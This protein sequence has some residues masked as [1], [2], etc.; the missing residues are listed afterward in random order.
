LYNCILA[1]SYELELLKSDVTKIKNGLKKWSQRDWM[2]FNILIPF[3]KACIKRDP[4]GVVLII[5]P[6][7][8]Y[9]Y[10]SFKKA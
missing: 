6:L 3:D 8:I 9:I 4:Y 10:I 2:P 7:V 1:A 5:G